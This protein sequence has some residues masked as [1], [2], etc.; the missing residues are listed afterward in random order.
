MRG[1]GQP[2]RGSGEQPL[3]RSSSLGKLARLCPQRSAPA[4]PDGCSLRA[5]FELSNNSPGNVQISKKI[6][7]AD[8]VPVAQLR[9]RSELQV[10]GSGKLRLKPSFSLF[11]FFFFFFLLKK[12]CSETYRMDVWREE[13][14]PV[15]STLF[16]SMSSSVVMSDTPSARDVA[17]SICR[18]IL[19]E[20]W[21][22]E[23][24][25]RLLCLSCLELLKCILRCFFDL[26][27][28]VVCVV[29]L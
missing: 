4:S 23:L 11:F 16:I 28:I 9:K 13:A 19:R 3:L 7:V 1:S 2:L 6:V 12:S 26:R 20:G 10:W 21:M 27:K 8:A 5:S 17:K 25:V 24:Q 22:P 15:D 29:V 14:A 18:K